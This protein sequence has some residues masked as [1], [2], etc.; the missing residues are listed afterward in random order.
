MLASSIPTSFTQAFG[1]SAGASQIRAIPAAS[2]ISITPGA[3]SLTDG[4]P[5]LNF[6]PVAAGGVPM[7][8][9]DLNGILNEITAAIQWQQVA[10]L[11]VYNSTFST[12]IG[13]YP[14]GAVLRAASTIGMW[15][16]TADNNSTNP[17]TGGA[18]WKLIGIS[19]EQIQQA[20]FISAT[21]SGTSDAIT[22]IYM[23]AIT[24]LTN[25][26]SLMVRGGSAN[27]T[28]T[29]TFTPAPGVI[30]AAAIV[31]GNGLPLVAGDIA[32]AGHWVELQYDS[33][34]AKWVLL[35]PATGITSVSASSMQQTGVSGSVSGFTASAIGINNYNCTVAGKEAVLE[36]GSNLYMT[37][38]AFSKTINANGTVGAPLSI[39]A[40]R[41]ANTWYYPY[42]WY[43]ATNGLTAVL[44]PSLTA[45]TAPVGYVSADYHCLLSGANLTDGTGNKYLMQINTVDNTSNF[46]PLAGSNT[47]NLPII[48]TGV[49][50]NIN[51][52][53]WA[54]IGLSGSCPPNAKFVKIVA[55][56]PSGSGGSVIVA[57]T[58]Q[59]GAFGSITNP[60]P[61]SLNYGGETHLFEFTLNNPGASPTICWA[62]SGGGSAMAFESWR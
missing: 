13:G 55:T 53:V 54:S 5:P 6:L 51:T 46:V 39:M 18:G 31:K 43:N 27:A 2:Q 40:T 12:A 34:L 3:A 28:T 21:A 47:P 35:N 7:S 52:P 59:Y 44:D 33:S 62:A 45:P 60:P 16:S 50:G 19:A 56:N 58:T 4:F 57:P 36:N 30:G 17:E 23:P 11:P 14:A 42:L 38:R 37:V 61:I 32:G 1:A 10:G 48:A 25:G 26:M 22:A 41:A 29:P 20:A 9:K 24:T 15:L 8:G 49:S